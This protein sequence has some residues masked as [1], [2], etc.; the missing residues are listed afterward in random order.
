MSGEFASRPYMRFSRVDR[1]FPSDRVFLEGK[2][3][4]TRADELGEW[5]QHQP[6]AGLPTQQ[7]TSSMPVG[8]PKSI[9]GTV[10]A[11]P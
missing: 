1:I 9:C 3:T 7:K 10:H 11:S 8:N 6:F 2:P 4:A 5:L